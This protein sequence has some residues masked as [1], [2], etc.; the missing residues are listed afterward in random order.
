MNT[1]RTFILETEYL[2]PWPT[3]SKGLECDAIIKIK[4]FTKFRVEEHFFTSII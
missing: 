2:L 4:I 1:E 3:Y